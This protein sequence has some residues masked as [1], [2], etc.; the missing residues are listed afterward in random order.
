M[1]WEHFF[2]CRHVI[3]ILDQN[4]DFTYNEHKICLCWVSG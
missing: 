2:F 4:F 3:G 1:G